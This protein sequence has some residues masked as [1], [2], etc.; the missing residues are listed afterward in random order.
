MPAAADRRT[1]AQRRRQDAYFPDTMS[2]RARR[3]VE[4]IAT[5]AVWREHTR[6]SA[7][8]AA[9]GVLEL[10]DRECRDLAAEVIAPGCAP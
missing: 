1:W 5:A 4:A 10:A 7:S 2:R 9:V 6:F 3:L 8:D